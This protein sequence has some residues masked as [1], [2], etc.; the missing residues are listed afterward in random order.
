MTSLIRQIYRLNFVLKNLCLLSSEKVTLSSG[1]NFKILQNKS[2]NISFSKDEATLLSKNIFN[3]LLG[4]FICLWKRQQSLDSKSILAISS[5][6]I[7]SLKNVTN[8]KNPSL[9]TIF[10]SIALIASFY[11]GLLIF[12]SYLNA[13]YCGIISSIS[14]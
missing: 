10:L 7:A 4:L 9:A 13:L 5:S 1:L 2:L 14:S 8:I 11:S 3:K 6:T 12:S